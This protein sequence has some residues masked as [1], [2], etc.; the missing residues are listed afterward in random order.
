MT[1]KGMMHR[2]VMS[3]LLKSDLPPEELSLIRIHQE[4][5]AMIGAGMETTKAALI[6]ACFHIISD[7][8]IYRRLHQ[9]L[10]DAFSDPYKLPTLPELEKLPYLTAV[11]QE[12]ESIFKIVQLMRAMTEDTEQS[13]SQSS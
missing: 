4:A 3:E 5:I 11:I 8:E 9:E 13:L 1:A 2:T 12:C 7:R 6:R 10:R